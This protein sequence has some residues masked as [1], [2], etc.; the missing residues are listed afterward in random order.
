VRTYFFICTHEP[1]KIIPDIYDR[2]QLVIETNLLNSNDAYE[3]AH[4][5]CER[6]S[7]NLNK[8]QKLAIIKGARGR[9]RT[10]I[11]TIKAIK[12]AG[13]DNEEFINEQLK[14]HSMDKGHEQSVILYFALINQQKMTVKNL[15]S[16]IE[17]T[18]LDPVS[19]QYKFLGMIY[20][21]YD[22]RARQLF[23]SLIP[24]L[25]ERREKFD[26]LLRFMRLLNL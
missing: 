18:G 2:F 20:N 23:A 5:T 12:S 19:I 9:P 11:N 16:L 17:S 14:T 3:L 7:V 6:L 21:N 13:E 25:E 26:L 8:K 1:E 22:F 24:P 4:I 15:I 10:I